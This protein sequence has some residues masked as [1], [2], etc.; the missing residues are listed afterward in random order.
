MA[1]A[2]IEGDFERFKFNLIPVGDSL[3]S[4]AAGIVY[5][6]QNSISTLASGFTKYEADYPE[7]QEGAVEMMRTFAAEFGV[8]YVTP[9]YEYEHVDDVKFR[10]FDFGISTKSLEGT[11][12]FANT[13]STPPPSIV[14]DY[15]DSKLDICRQHIRFHAH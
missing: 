1:L 6:L 7:Q 5:C 15:I 9:V 12:L 8:S 13:F 3:A 11:S 10:L 14:C 2:N 4:H